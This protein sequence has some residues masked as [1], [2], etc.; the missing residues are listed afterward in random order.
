VYGDRD[1]ICFA[2]FPTRAGMHVKQ[3]LGLT[4]GEDSVLLTDG[5]AA[6]ESYAKKG[7]GD[8]RVMLRIRGEASLK[9]RLPTRKVWTKRSSS[10]LTLG[11]AGNPLRSDL[12]LAT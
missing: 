11:P 1:E 6:Y 10:P 2:W 9:R 4:Q 3:T 8:A 5:Y 7:R 12:S